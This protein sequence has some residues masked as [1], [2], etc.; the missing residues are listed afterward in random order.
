[1]YNKHQRQGRSEVEN[2]FGLVK[3]TWCELIRKTEMDVYFVPDMIICCYTLHNLV[4]GVTNVQVEELMYYLIL[5]AQED[6]EASYGFMDV[7]YNID[8]FDAEV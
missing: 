1:M 8:I 3:Y 2:A 6:I 7:D 4:L 5:E